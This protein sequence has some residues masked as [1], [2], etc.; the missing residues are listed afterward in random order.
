MNETDKNC[1]NVKKW[2]GK[3]KNKIK[4]TGK[5]GENGKCHENEWN[6]RKF[7]K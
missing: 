6:N 7:E 2:L 5:V 1:W 4:G 3:N